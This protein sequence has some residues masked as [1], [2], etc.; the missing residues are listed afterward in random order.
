[1]AKIN[2]NESLA[3]DFKRYTPRMVPKNPPPK[4]KN[5]SFL[6]IFL[7]VGIKINP[8]NISRSDIISITIFISKNKTNKGIENNAPA[9]PVK[10]L[11]K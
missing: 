9:K 5:N 8:D 3:R 1:M 4:I 11:I 10:D 7:I 2:F 6:S